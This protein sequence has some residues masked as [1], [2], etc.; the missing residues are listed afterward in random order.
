MSIR[1]IKDNDDEKSCITESGY[2]YQTHST[3]QKKPKH[4]VIGLC[5]IGTQCLSIHKSSICKLNDN[6]H[7]QNKML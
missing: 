1:S 2:T 7:F 3:E 6:K 4:N 5:Y